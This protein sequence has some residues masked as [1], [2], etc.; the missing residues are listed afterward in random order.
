MTKPLSAM[1]DKEKAQLLAGTTG[2]QVPDN[3]LLED[4]EDIVVPSQSSVWHDST[5]DRQK[6]LSSLDKKPKRNILSRLI[7]DDDPQTLGK[8]PKD[9]KIQSKVPSE[10]N[11][12]DPD[13]DI[14]QE[15]AV[16]VP[17]KS[18][19]SWLRSAVRIILWV[20]HAFFMIGVLYFTYYMVTIVRSPGITDFAT[21]GTLIL[22]ISIQIS[23]FSAN[24]FVG[25]VIRR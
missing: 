17:P 15:G 20:I 11:D 23:L 24:T 25:T 7:S 4:E 12:F 3:D 10:D 9:K 2:E 5:K 14:N 8:Y 21:I 18:D 1:T 19:R 6:F 16:L 22:V 13:F